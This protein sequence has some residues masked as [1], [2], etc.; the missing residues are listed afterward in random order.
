[1]ARDAL[2]GFVIRDSLLVDNGISGFRVDGNAEGPHTILFSAL[3]GNGAG[4]LVPLEDDAL[5]DVNSFT[6]PAPIFLNTTDPTNPLYFQLDPSTSTDIS[7]GASDGSFMGARGVAGD[8][9]ADA[10]VTGFDFLSNEDLAQPT[11]PTT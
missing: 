9:D 11:M 8:F 10:D 4:G 1:L 7:L 5:M 3:T 2:P 6:S